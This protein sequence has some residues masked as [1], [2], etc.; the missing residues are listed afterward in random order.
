MRDWLDEVS[1]VFASSKKTERAFV[2]TLLF[3]VL[4]LVVGCFA[5]D[6]MNFPE[7]WAALEGPLRHTFALVFLGLSVISFLRLGYGAL[8]SYAKA[9][10]RLFRR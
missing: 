6:L 4:I 2:A 10:E 8:G 5:V 7:Q 1:A 9:R 3:P